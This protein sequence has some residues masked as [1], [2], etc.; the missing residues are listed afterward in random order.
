MLPKFMD[1]Y[2]D[3]LSA[4]PPKS[5]F[6]LCWVG[7]RNRARPRFQLQESHQK[8]PLPWLIPKPR[9]FISLIFAPDRTSAIFCNKAI[10]LKAAANLAHSSRS[11]AQWLAGLIYVMEEECEQKGLE[12]GQRT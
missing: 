1:L 2:V 12:D 6:S 4:M 10:Q 11:V 5:G 8:N 7:I 3:I 9:A